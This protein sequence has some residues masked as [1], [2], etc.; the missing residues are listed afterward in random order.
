[1]PETTSTT[2]IEVEDLSEKAPN[3]LVEMLDR[4]VEIELEA[5]I[6][7]GYGSAETRTDPSDPGEMEFTLYLPMYT[8]TADAKPARIK[9]EQQWLTA[10][11]FEG[12][13]EGFWDE[14]NLSAA[15]DEAARGD[16]LY[17]QW[18]ERNL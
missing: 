12:I 15:D 13:D 6:Y 10:D 17:E 5:E 14:L 7:F 11:C 2:Y 4:V 8:H 1:M 3:W 9:I 16:Y 18:K